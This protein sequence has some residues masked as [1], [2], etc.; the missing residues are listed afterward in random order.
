ME[1]GENM[2]LLAVAYSQD[3]SGQAVG[4]DLGFVDPSQLLPE[5]RE[6]VANMKLGETTIIPSRYG[7]HIIRFEQQNGNLMHLRE[8]LLN[9]SGY[10]AWKTAQ[11]QNFKIKKIINIG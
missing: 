3:P 10:Q 6:P 11:V 8:I 5:L 2:A 9:N 1:N 7:L 4:G